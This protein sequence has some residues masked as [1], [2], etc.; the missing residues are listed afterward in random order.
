VGYGSFFCYNIPGEDI[1]RCKIYAITCEIEGDYIMLGAIIGDI[2]GSRFEFNNHRSKDFELFTKDCFVTDDSIM[3]LAVAKAV[4]ACN[5]D[6]EQLGEHA[7]KYMQT[8][9]R[10]YPD[11]GFGGMFKKWVFSENPEP[12]NSFG[13]GAAMRVSPCG[14]IAQTE[15]EA[16]L[17]SGKFTEITHNHPEGMKGAQAT[18]VAVFLAR[19]GATKHEIKERIEKDYYALG[20]NL[21]SIRES[22]KFNESC[23][24]TVPQAIKAFIE[25]I[26]FEDAIRNA[27]SIGGDSDTLAAITGSIAEAYY[28]VPQYLKRKAL[29]YLDRE[30]RDIYREW[31]RFFKKNYPD[32]K[33]AYLTKYTGKLENTEKFSE[34]YRE[35]YHFLHTHPE[36]EL[37]MY[38]DILKN[39]G[40]YWET[41]SMRSANVCDLDG[42]C[43]LALI[44]GAFRA[45]YFSKGVL[46]EF[47]KGGHIDNW[48]NRLKTLDEGRKPEEDRPMLKQVRIRLNPFEE[49]GTNELLVTEKQIVIKYGTPD[50]GNVTHLF[51]FGEESEAGEIS[52]SVMRDCLEADGWDDGQG[53]CETGFIANLYELEAE[54]TDGRVAVHRGAFDRAHIPEKAFKVFIDIIRATINT[55]S[56]GGI[57]N[58]DGFMSALKPG[59]VKY[60]GVEFSSGRIYHYRTTDL[61][62]DVGDTVIVPVGEDNREQEVTVKTVDICQWDDT[63][64]PLEKT[65]QILRMADDKGDIIPS[66][67]FPGKVPIL[68]LSDETS[69]DNR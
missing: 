47:V 67:R 23:Q 1:L 16:K 30:L 12:Y 14:F 34:F 31:E 37:D 20:F 66:L 53:S 65:K 6:W 21:D 44:T 42:Q 63:P 17:L 61:R 24:D 13:N 10:K 55:Y 11:C 39:N 43:I 9:G 28:G 36:Y 58:L 8:I 22:Y 49:D 38:E 5:N 2:V 46:H 60:C 57:V 51:E 69:A 48:L 26:S 52:L 33:F 54:Y 62:I 56:F 32:Q 29:T 18:A 7:T 45:D 15:D 19:N 68:C 27:I 64:Y 40:L 3:T 41:Y 4:L 50:D 59:E 35:F 25:S